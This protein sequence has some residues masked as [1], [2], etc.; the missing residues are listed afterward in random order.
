[1]RQSEFSANL[2]LD[3]ATMEAMHRLCAYQRMRDAGFEVGR[4]FT[5][6]APVRN[7]AKPIP[8]DHSVSACGKQLLSF[9]AGFAVLA[10]G[11]AIFG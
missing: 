11:L 6:P 7:R 5:R 1:M 4:S 10:I 2:S 3:P 9:A 8:L